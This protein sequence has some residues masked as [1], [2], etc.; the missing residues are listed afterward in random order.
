MKRKLTSAFYS[1]FII[2]HLL[3]LALSTSAQ[4]SAN[5]YRIRFSDR[6]LT[7][8]ISNDPIWQK[9]PSSPFKY[10]GVAPNDPVKT[11]T[12]ADLSASMKAAWINSENEEGEIT[13]KL[14]VLMEIKDDIYMNDGDSSLYEYCDCKVKA[15]HPEDSPEM[16][17]DFRNS[18][19]DLYDLG[20]TDKVQLSFIRADP[21]I[22][23]TVVTPVLGA[24]VSSVFIKY[25]EVT[26]K[27]AQV[28]AIGKYTIEWEIDMGQFMKLD[29]NE[30]K[31][32]MAFGFDLA[33]NDDDDGGAR[34]SKISWGP[35]YDDQNFALPSQWNTVI[36]KDTVLKGFITEPARAN[37][38]K[39]AVVK[40]AF[41]MFP[42][43]N[44][45]SML[46]IEKTIADNEA[47]DVEI[48]DLTGHQV[49]SFTIQK[50][51][52][53]A[54][55]PLNELSSGVYLVKVSNSS[56]TQVEKLFVR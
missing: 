12:D 28:S 8:G 36:L 15:T 26:I 44:E 56:L 32:D 16:F 18:K 13:T 27:A 37:S 9:I 52:N 33:V 17:L 20:S 39:R 1:S 24:K 25:P 5:I 34:D 38:T 19:S 14:Y 22:G 46:R 2:G 29:V 23:Q 48:L 49:R 7:D 11:F 21:A 3:I 31:E 55:F 43:P 41:K 51:E 42:N 40:N 35:N 54:A 4:D 47:V 10:K 6:P 50:G 30:I 53:S 45:D